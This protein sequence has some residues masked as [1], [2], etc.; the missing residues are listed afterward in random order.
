MDKKY[1][2]GVA[3][4]LDLWW[5]MNPSWWLRTKADEKPKPD[6]FD[7]IYRSYKKYEVHKI[8]GRWS[9]CWGVVL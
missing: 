9:L 8:L 3:S 6:T 5:R 4:W 7:E 1:A 2:L